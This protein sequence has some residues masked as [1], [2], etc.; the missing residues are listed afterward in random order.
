[1]KPTNVNSPTTSIQQLNLC[2]LRHEMNK[3]RRAKNA[4]RLVLS[5]QMN[6]FQIIQKCS[7]LKEQ[8]AFMDAKEH[9][10]TEVK[11]GEFKMIFF[12]YQIT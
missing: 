3:K 11:M 10:G 7:F 8:K 1:M 5:L 2:F 12:Y 6:A 4:P 9:A